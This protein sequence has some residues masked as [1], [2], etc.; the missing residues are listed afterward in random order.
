[1][2]TTPEDKKSGD[3]SDKKKAKPN[4]EAV[5][6]KQ[7]A[8]EK[9][10]KQEQDDLSEKKKQRTAAILKESKRLYKHFSE[11]GFTRDSFIELGE[12]VKAS[13]PFEQLH[14]VVA[15]LIMKVAANMIDGK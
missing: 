14:P 7:E 12:S 4:G 3:K 1:M 8:S 13:K 2:E 5:E 6:R 10:Q 15:K 9:P 11:V